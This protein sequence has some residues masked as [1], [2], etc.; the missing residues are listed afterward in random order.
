MRCTFFSYEVLSHWVFLV[1]FLMRQPICVL[2]DIQG[3]VL[4]YISI[5]V[6]VYQDLFDVYQDLMYLSFSVKLGQ[7]LPINR[8]ASFIVNH[9]SREVVRITLSILSTLL[10][11]SFLFYNTLSARSFY[12]ISISQTVNLNLGMGKIS[13]RDETL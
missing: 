10:L 3:R 11:Y 6:N 13:A 8:R 2:L 7:I 9:S 1:R 12:F 5:I 4:W